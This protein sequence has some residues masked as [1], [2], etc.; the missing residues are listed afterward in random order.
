M[1]VEGVVSIDSLDPQDRQAFEELD[2]AGLFE[3]SEARVAFLRDMAGNGA[4]AAAT[5]DLDWR[6]AER[7]MGKKK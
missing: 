7:V 5:P 3:T 2:A 1:G 4:K 6:S